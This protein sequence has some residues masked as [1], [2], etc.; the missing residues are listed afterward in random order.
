MHKVRR[1]INMI[2]CLVFPVFLFILAV[3]S[4]CADSE[5]DISESLNAIAPVSSS[6][7]AEESSSAVSEIEALTGL[8]R[9]ASSELDIPSPVGEGVFQPQSVQK[10]WAL[11][12]AWC[13]IAAAAALAVS[14]IVSLSHSKSAKR[15]EFE[16]KTYSGARMKYKRHRLS[17]RYDSRK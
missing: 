13:M 17:N 15:K 1:V 6:V 7:S 12:T 4:A 2:A 3:V 16:R 9:V 8:P 14:V 5:T 10:T 11:I